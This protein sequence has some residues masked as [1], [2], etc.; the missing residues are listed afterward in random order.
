MFTKIVPLF[1]IAFDGGRGEKNV[2][3]RTIVY[4]TEQ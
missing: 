2:H 3:G 4:E 1:I